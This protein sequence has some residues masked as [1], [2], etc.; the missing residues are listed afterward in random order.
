MKYYKNHQKTLKL[1]LV[2]HFYKES[3]KLVQKLAIYKKIF[4]SQKNLFNKKKFRV[5]LQYFYN[6]VIILIT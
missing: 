2:L 5:A 1:K 3:L 6:F 4:N